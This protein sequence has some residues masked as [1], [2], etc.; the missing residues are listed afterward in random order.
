MLHSNSR[1]KD[2]T[3]D[4]RVRTWLFVPARGVF[5]ACL[6]YPDQARPGD[7]PVDQAALGRNHATPEPKTSMHDEFSLEAWIRLPDQFTNFS[8]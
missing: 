4:C 5:E 6:S 8:G 3:P 7:A 1:I 2:E